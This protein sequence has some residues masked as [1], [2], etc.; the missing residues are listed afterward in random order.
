MVLF[1]IVIMLHASSLGF[2]VPTTATLYPLASVSPFPLLHGP[3]H[4]HSTLCF[5]KF[6]STYKQGHEGFSSVCL[7][8]FTQH[9][10]LQADPSMLMQLAS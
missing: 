6:D 8:C 7:A 1:A 10:V 4:R 9:N 5:Y 2:L 3:G